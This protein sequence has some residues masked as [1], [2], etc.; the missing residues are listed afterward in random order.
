MY[1]TISQEKLKFLSRRFF[2]EIFPLY[3]V[4]FL[5]SPL[6]RD[7]VWHLPSDIV[8][9]ST[10]ISETFRLGSTICSYL[11]SSFK[12]ILTS[13]VEILWIMGSQLRFKNRIYLG[14][15]W[16][17]LRAKCSCSILAVKAV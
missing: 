16:E 10:Q 2:P 8:R 7:L 13:R 12:H 15:L 3:C 6:N 9:K 17:G 4:H 11:F 1:Q 14:S 5:R